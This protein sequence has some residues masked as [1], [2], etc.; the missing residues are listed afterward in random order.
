MPHP[1]ATRRYRVKFRDETLYSCHL[2][3]YDKRSTEV[4]THTNADI[5]GCEKETFSASE[6]SD[7]N[8]SQR[9]NPILQ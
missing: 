9:E 8:K 1:V 5:L 4:A 2:W 6:S 3:A 7:R